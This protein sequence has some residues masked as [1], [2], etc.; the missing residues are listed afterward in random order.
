MRVCE[1]GHGR[2]S[3]VG[4]SSVGTLV[5]TS[6]VHVHAVVAAV[7]VM[8]SVDRGKPVGGLSG[9]LLGHRQASLGHG[10]LAQCGRER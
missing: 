9:L 6:G 8:Y 7:A 5:D 3:V 10:T 1:R 4:F 2:V